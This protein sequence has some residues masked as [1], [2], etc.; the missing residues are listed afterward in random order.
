MNKINI[1]VDL[2]LPEDLYE[3]LLKDSRLKK[4]SFEGLFLKYIQDRMES[5][6]KK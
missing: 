2:R 1:K 5:E 3:F 6:K 4:L